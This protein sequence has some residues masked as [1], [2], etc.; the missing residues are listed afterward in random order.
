M[1]RFRYSLLTLL[2]VTAMVAMGVALW[3]L[4][5]ELMPLREEVADLRR[6][7]GYL[8]V[9]DKGKGYVVGVPTWDD[10]TWRWRIHVPEGKQLGIYH[11]ENQIPSDGISTKGIENR[12]SAIGIPMPGTHLVH[13]SVRKNA[14]GEWQLRLNAGGVGVR[15]DI[16]PGQT[17]WPESA[18]RSSRTFLIEGDSDTTEIVPGEPLQLLRHIVTNK[19]T[20]TTITQKGSP[21]D[22]LLIWVRL[23]DK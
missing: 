14:Y 3:R 22:G 18:S 6:E 13:A 15:S 8:H 16:D 4:N 21:T 5:A 10:M 23:V 17:G 12:A 7:T 20:P 2:I 1:P 11:V 19:Q 9:E